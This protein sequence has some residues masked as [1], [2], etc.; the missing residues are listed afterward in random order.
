MKSVV[1]GVSKG[2]IKLHDGMQWSLGQMTA[3]YMPDVHHAL[4]G[5]KGGGDTLA[6]LFPH[7]GAMAGFSE[8]DITRF[9]Y[10]VGQDPDGYR[11]VNIGQAQYTS[12]LINY[13]FANPDAYDET[14]GGTERALRQISA[15]GGEIEG[16]LGL[17]RQ[18]SEI[19]KSADGDAKFN[20][21]KQA[22]ATWAKSL[23]SV[24]IG[25]G[26]GAATSPVGGALAAVALNDISGQVIDG[27]FGEPRDR[28]DDALYTSGK[29][30]DNHKE[31]TMRATQYAA[32][33]SE[34]ARPSGMSEAQIE[35]AVREGVQDGNGTAHDVIEEYRQKRGKG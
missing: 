26:V 9:M 13:H 21:D 32:D 30:L 23:T 24:G 16:I 35:T 11:A 2:D 28:G 5:G 20:K 8:Q 6:D 10:E 22:Y 25:I 15:R 27:L 14:D 7:N 1:H 29:S 18:D 31:S 3:E 19:Q 4:S 34:H 12:D 17:A 33:L